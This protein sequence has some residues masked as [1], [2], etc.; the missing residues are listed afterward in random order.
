MSVLEWMRSIFRI[1]PTRPLE[2]ILL[3]K[4]VFGIST[5]IPLY[6]YVD[7]SGL[8]DRLRYLLST[9]RH[10]VIHG[11]SKQ[12]KTILRKKVLSD[13][14]AIVIQCSTTTT[15]F[16]VYADILRKLG[17][18]SSLQIRQTSSTS[19][20][21]SAQLGSELSSPMAKINSNVTT[22]TTAEND[23][24][25]NGDVSGT[26]AGNL[27]Y[28]AENIRKSNK[29]IV[30]E[31]FHYL[32]EKDQRNLA[33]DLKALWDYKVFMIIVGVWAEQNLLTYYNGDL[34]GRIEE[35][36]VQWQNNELAQVVN[37]GE[38]V[39][40]I[41]FSDDLRQAILDDANQNVGLLQRILE[42]YCYYA[43]IT[44]TQ[45]II[46]ELTRFEPL[47]KSR[48]G[49]CEEE[50]V[51]YRQFNDAVQRGFR[52]YED[53]ELKVY[54]HILRVFCESTDQEIKAGLHRD[55]LLI[56]TQQY[57]SRIRLSDLSAALNK[58][59][60]LQA[61]RRISPL[62]VSYNTASS[63]QKLQLIDREFLFYRKYGNPQWSW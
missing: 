22:S 59:N 56:K 1:K 11:A 63:S 38:Q 43:G 8:D 23:I 6:T 58:I 15:L 49:I 28:V 39:L 2:P 32:S 57:E 35:I 45:T 34:S 36:D 7:R 62:V 37:K 9:D 55:T 10:I 46:Q 18:N 21:K 5:N 12:G 19:E 47:E 30:V 53:S 20:E 17:V 41:K 31:D 42:K 33:F 54:K 4:D 25:V 16:D 26:D 24:E 13:D 48:S 3:L 40:K 61:D 50:E 14:E 44:Q 60:Q 29:R 27:G 52:G 51:R